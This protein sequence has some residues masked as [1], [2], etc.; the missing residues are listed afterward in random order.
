[1]L[2]FIKKAGP[3]VAGFL[4]GVGIYEVWWSRNE[5]TYLCLHTEEALRESEKVLEESNKAL[6]QLN[7]M[8]ESQ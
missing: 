4:I 3:I 5:T 1:M 6:E 8:I 7:E 2:N